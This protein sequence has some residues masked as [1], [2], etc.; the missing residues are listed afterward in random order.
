MFGPW[1]ER[2]DPFKGALLGASLFYVGNLITATG[3]ATR[4]MT[5]VII[6]YGLFGGAGLG[7]AYLT[8]VS[9]LQKWFPE[10]RGN[11]L[12]FFNNH[13]ILL[14]K[15]GLAAGFAVC[16]FGAGSI[17]APYTQSYLIGL[18][19]V[20]LSFIILGSCYFAIMCLAGA[21]L[22]MPPPGYTFTPDVLTL[23]L[24]R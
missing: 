1:L 3:V 20:H 6:G 10:Y 18:Y 24:T 15:I 22:R 12:F 13:F 9:P 5:V 21:V 14:K 19:N 23:L 2:Y 7:L 8:P 17:I 11:I 16:G 4:Q